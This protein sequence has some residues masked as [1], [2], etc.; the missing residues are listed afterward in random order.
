MLAVADDRETPTPW[1]RSQLT[2]QNV[3]L[4]IVAVFNIGG[5]YQTQQQT[6]DTTSKLEA[7]VADLE[8]RIG[9]ERA[10]LDPVYMLRELA[11]AQNAEV[12]RRLDS[13]ERRLTG[14]GVER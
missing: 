7:R 9:E 6:K 8:K 14:R 3:L 4:I 5:W 13:I 12:L 11:V 2:V 1:L 10:R